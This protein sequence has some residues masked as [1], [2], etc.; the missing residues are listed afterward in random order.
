MRTVPPA[1]RMRR[2]EVSEAEVDDR[3]VRCTA[4]SATSA[5]KQLGSMQPMYLRARAAHTRRAPARRVLRN[6]RM[7]RSSSFGRGEQLGKGLVLAQTWQ[8]LLP[9]QT[10]QG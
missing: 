4:F 3:W 10:W 6:R 7:E 2:R 5:S 8:G 1:C 9:A